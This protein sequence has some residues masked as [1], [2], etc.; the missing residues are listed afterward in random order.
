MRFSALR[1]LPEALWGHLLPSACPVCEREP[2]RTDCRPY[3]AACFEALESWG[4]ACPRCGRRVPTGEVCGPCRLNPPPL[5]AAAHALA[6]EGNAREAIHLW[7]FRGAY[8]LS[9]PFADR[10]GPLVE[11]LPEPFR[12]A[13]LVPVPPH[14]WRILGKDYHPA[15][16][17]AEALARRTGRAV[18][19]P[20]VKHAL[21]RPQSSLDR[22]ARLR[23]VRGTFAARGPAPDAAILVDDVC[24]TGATLREAAAVL[25]GAGARRLAALTLARTP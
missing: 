19:R 8:F 20:L 21:R 6:Y 16:L 15:S 1:A 11:A 18:R 5:D 2:D 4:P 9:A 14:P 25:A 13:P 22:A 17:L 10:L 23:S 3:C 24:T 12:N 7:K